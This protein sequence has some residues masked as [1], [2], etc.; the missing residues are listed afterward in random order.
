MEIIRNQVPTNPRLRIPVD[1][2]MSMSTPPRPKAYEY[3]SL[4]ET[5]PRTSLSGCASP[6]E[7]NTTHDREVLSANIGKAS[8]PT[9]AT[10]SD[11]ESDRRVATGHSSW[12]LP[13]NG[14]TRA[15]ARSIRNHAASLATQLS[16]GMI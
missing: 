5:T 10:D 3:C 15:D 2:D 13:R 7:H 9:P 8:P 4:S 11:P 16:H 1:S 14:S 6:L 12:S